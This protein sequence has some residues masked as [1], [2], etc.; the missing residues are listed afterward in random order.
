MKLRIEASCREEDLLGALIEAKNI[1]KS[2]ELVQL[3]IKVKH[4][5]PSKGEQL[6]S[7]ISLTNE[8]YPPEVLEI[9]KLK[10]QVQDLIPNN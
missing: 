1:M 8:S 9:Y 7:W 3:D 5:I 2:V 4:P 10:K 6:H